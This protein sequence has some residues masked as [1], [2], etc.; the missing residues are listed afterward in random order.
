[1]KGMLMPGND[2]VEL[3][4]L[5]YRYAYAVDKCDTQLFLSVF[6]PDGR[7][8]AYNPG[9]T[10]PFNDVR[11]HEQLAGITEMMRTMFVGTMHSM[12]NPMV[13]VD[14][15]TATGNVLCVARHTKKD[16]D[17]VLIITIRYEDS[18]VRQDGEWKISDRHIR[19]LWAE[20]TELTETGF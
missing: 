12:M 8:R 19:F 15:D 20:R 13:D 2:I 14:G 9:E 17:E 11:G 3:N 16:S 7:V 1:M 10:E 5:A 18:F 4:Q 6:T